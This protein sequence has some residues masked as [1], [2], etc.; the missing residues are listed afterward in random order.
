MESQ[1][2]NDDVFRRHIS[3]RMGAAVQLVKVYE[4]SLLKVV[5]TF[6]TLKFKLGPASIDGDHFKV[7]IIE[8]HCSGREV[9]RSNIFPHPIG[10][11]SGRFSDGLYP[12]QKAGEGTPL[13]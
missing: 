11:S 2:Q 12:H 7:V 13:E 4:S 1:Q 6:E 9:L 8:V 10:S 3:E 5:V